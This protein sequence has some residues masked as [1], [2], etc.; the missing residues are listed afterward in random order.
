MLPSVKFLFLFLL[1]LVKECKT[2]GEESLKFLSILKLDRPGSGK[3]SSGA[4][5]LQK[6]I[7]ALQ[8]KTNVSVVVVVVY[9]INNY[10]ISLPR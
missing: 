1:E 6:S 3:I 9:E 10:I 5:D 4:N 8:R 2:I 7:R